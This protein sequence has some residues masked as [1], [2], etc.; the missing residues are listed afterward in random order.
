MAMPKDR[1]EFER[2]LQNGRFAW[3]SYYGTA[4]R[5]PWEKPASEKAE[6]FALP[7]LPTLEPC[8]ADM[9]AQRGIWAAVQQ[10]IDAAAGAQTATAYRTLSS[11]RK[12]LGPVILFFKKV[13]RKL[14]KVLLGWYIF[15]ILETQSEYNARVLHAVALERDMLAKQLSETDEALRGLT[16]AVRALQEHGEEQLHEQ[17]RAREQLEER[18]RKIENLPTSDDVFYH[19]FEEKFR[20]SRKEIKQSLKNYVAVVKEH[21]PDFSKGR[22]VDVGSGR[23]EWLDLL[24]ENGAVDYV[25]VDLNEVQNSVCE[26]RGHTTV[27]QDC[28]AYLKEQPPQSIDLITG[29]Q[30]IEHLAMPD[31]MELLRQSYRTLKKGGMILFETQNPRNITVGA[32]TFFLDPSHHRVMEPRMVSFLAKWNGFGEI[33]IIDNNTGARGNPIAFTMDGV[34][35]EIRQLYQDVNDMKWMIWGPQDYALFAIR[36]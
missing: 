4:P 34:P 20:G 26:A 10:D 21:L 25:G 23:G 18:L 12:V 15:P 36:E 22:F 35:D 2:R 19:Y 6:T 30:I 7:P 28:I 31:L 32:D 1:K 24:Q 3:E 5:E 29:F 17:A 8:R 16:A 33:R 9:L 27:C 11:H 13:V 14:L